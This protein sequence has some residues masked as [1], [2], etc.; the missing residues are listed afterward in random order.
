MRQTI[1]FS[2]IALAAL[3]GA[4]FFVAGEPSAARNYQYCGADYASGVRQCGFDT[5]EQCV[6]MISGRG[7]SCT[8]DHFL[9]EIEWFAPVRSKGPRP[10]AA[11][12]GGLSARGDESWPSFRT[13][14]QGA[15]PFIIGVAIASGPAIAEGC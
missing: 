14:A 15:S 5:M 7:G 12:A 13:A 8:R 6:A 4:A 11:A 2:T 3:A 10:S 1:A 9:A